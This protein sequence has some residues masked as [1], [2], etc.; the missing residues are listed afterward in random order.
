MNENKQPYNSEPDTLKHIRRVNEL[1]LVAAQKLI[2]RAIAHDA[3]KL[4]EP[5]K[6]MYDELTPLLAGSTYGSDE[7]K[8]FLASLRPALD[9]HYAKNSHHPEHY[10]N[11]VND[12]DLFDLIEMFFDWKAAGE[13][14]NNGSIIESIDINKE[15]FGLS[16]Q[17]VSIMKNTAKRLWQWQ[18]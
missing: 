14:H 1:L 2:Q 8:G 12:M 6:S 10:E 16:N 11:G 18:E 17:V 15:R 13:R 9:N 4:L 7:Y 3:S 5:E